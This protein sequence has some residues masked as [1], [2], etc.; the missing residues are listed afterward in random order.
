MTIPPLYRAALI[1]HFAAL[2]D[3]D[4]RQLAFALTP[5]RRTDGKPVPVEVLDLAAAHC[6]DVV[7]LSEAHPEIDS[8]AANAASYAEH[9]REFRKQIAARSANAV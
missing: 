4:L 9:A 6:D 7:R 1:D 8:A 3:D 2:S 5:Y